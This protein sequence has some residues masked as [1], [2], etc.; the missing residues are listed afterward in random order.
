MTDLISK[1]FKQALKLLQAED[2]KM[3]NLPFEVA[4]FLRVHG[5]QGVIDNGGYRY[6]FE[7]D[8]DENP[9]YFEVVN[10]YQIIGCLAQAKEF[11]RVV[12]T[13]PFDN[14]HLHCKRRNQFMDD[15]WNEDKYCIEI[16]GD[17]LC[18]DEEVWQN[19]EEYYIQH[20]DKFA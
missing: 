16:W 13:F 7:M 20:Q 10:A 12:S 19:L 9:S 3:E 5:A 1:A 18:G 8:W 2:D 6:F 14:P 4:T 15:H 11:K 17:G